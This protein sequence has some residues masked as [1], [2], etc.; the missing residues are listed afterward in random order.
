MGPRLSISLLSSL[1]RNIHICACVF[2]VQL[3]RNRVRS[4]RLCLSSLFCEQR[5]Q[6]LFIAVGVA[7]AS[8]AGYERPLKQQ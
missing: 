1:K 3:E 6:T 8:W 5:Q 4:L 7:L 2:V